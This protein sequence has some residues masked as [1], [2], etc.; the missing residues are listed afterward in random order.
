M[1]EIIYPGGFNV[2]NISPDG[3]HVAAI[4][5]DGYHYSLMLYNVDSG[6]TKVLYR[7]QKVVDGFWTFRKE[8]RDITWV[9]NDMIAVDYGYRADS[10]NLAGKLIAEVGEAVLRKADYNNPDSNMLLVL[11]DI[12]DGHMAKVDA[13]TGEKTKFRLP[14]GGKPIHWAFDR[15]GE[16]RAVTMIDS[17]FWRKANKITSW[18]KPGVTAEW[19]LLEQFKVTDDYWRPMFVPDDDNTIIVSSR[20]GRDTY[21]IFPYNTKTHALGDMMAGHPA[22]DILA[23]GGVN[24]AT[25]RSVK[26]SGMIPQQVWF[27]PN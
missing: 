3:R 8:P 2:A 18:Y 5:F 9:T 12:E 24:E 16:L 27:D 25:F 7:G 22:V 21:A 23:V 26:T 10:I 6:D 14:D 11:T 4:D 20:S 19:E 15:S 17:G 1:A 13:R